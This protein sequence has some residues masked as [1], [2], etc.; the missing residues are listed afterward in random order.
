MRGTRIGSGCG[1]NL[2]FERSAESAQLFHIAVED[3]GFI[4]KHLVGSVDLA[5]GRSMDDWK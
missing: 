3:V 2:D 1:V 4:R 5:D